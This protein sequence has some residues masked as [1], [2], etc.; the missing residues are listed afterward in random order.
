MKSTY[1]TFSLILNKTDFLLQEFKVNKNSI[2]DA[3]S[4]ALK[5]RIESTKNRIINQ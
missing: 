1:S 3:V 5:N 4:K 2:V